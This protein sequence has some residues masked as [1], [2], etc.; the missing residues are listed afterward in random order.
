[1]VDWY[2]ASRIRQEF[3]LQ[4][5]EAKE[6]VELINEERERK[7]YYIPRKD[8]VPLESIIQKLGLKQKKNA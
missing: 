3:K 6:L 8:R 7:G 2:S 5:N 1:M 4:Y